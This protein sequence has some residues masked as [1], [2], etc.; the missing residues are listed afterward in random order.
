VQ[1]VFEKGLVDELVVAMQGQSGALPLLE[2]TLDQLVRRRNGYQLTFQAY[3]QI[4]G[5][6]G[7]L[8]QHAE[9]T[10]QGLPTNDHRQ[11]ARAIFL[12]LIQPGVTEQD[13]TRRRAARSEFDQD[14]PT[15]E[16]RI[17]ETLD[18]FIRA[19]LLTA[20]Q[21]DGT[22][23]VE[24]SH[25]A[26]IRE[27]KRLAEW[28]YEARSDIRLQE[29]LSEDTR[30]WEQRK[31][32]GDRLYRGTQLKEA[33]AWARR[34]RPSTSE[35]AF[36]QASAR[37]RLFWLASVVAFVLVL[38]SSM[39]ITSWSVFFQPNP[40]LVTSLQDNVVGSLRWC[41]DHA[42]SQKTTIRF[43]PGLKGVIELTEGDL[44][45]PGGKSF[46]LIGPGANQLAIS[47]GNFNAKMHIAQGA[48]LTISGLSFINSQTVIDAFLFNEGT[49]TISNSVISHNQTSA[50][51]I[52]YGG[53]IEN[54]GTLTAIDSHIVN[55]IARG[56][57]KGQGG[58]IFNEGKLTV[59]RTVFSD[60][61]AISS[62]GYGLG[63]AID[64]S[65]S[66]N[67][68]VI[69]STFSMNTATGDTS[70]YGG[71]IDSEGKLMVTDSTFLHNLVS[72]TSSDGLSDGYGGGIYNGS[73]GTVTITGSLFSQNSASAPSTAEGGGIYNAGKTTLN[74]SSLLNNTASGD[75][76]RN[77]FLKGIAGGDASGG[78]IYNGFEP[79]NLTVTNS[80]ISNNVA[81]G[82]QGGDG[83]GGGIYNDATLTVINTTFW[84]NEASYAGGGIL[85]LDNKSDSAMISFCT[86]YANTAEKGGGIWATSFLDNGDVTISS[87]IVADNSAR[88][89]P[90][91]F[92]TLISNGYNMVENFA[93][94]V[95]LNPR[96]D[97]QVTF[98]NL[99]VQPT[100]GNNGGPTQT[101]APL[102]GS[103]AIDAV[104][105]PLCSV[106]IT[107]VSGQS[108]TITTDQR[109][110]PRPDGSENTCDIGAY[111][112]SY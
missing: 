104:P 21:V 110:A 85:S 72:S 3:R 9:E 34:N 24:V 111:E 84:H 36:L 16:Q 95:G 81:D 66:G 57:S 73:T 70:G 88:R 7:A 42:S 65:S 14:E 40:T 52:A 18:R 86:L 4:G 107:T 108:M 50:G 49:L 39:G 44:L 13:S 15:Q 82:H 45:F 35:A 93:G 87:S 76:Y 46:T 32:P 8:S 75:G 69:G 19:R 71:S 41:V 63:G 38:A 31:H 99:G 33:Q 61:S 74:Q 2:F 55:N 80:T 106:I 26:L 1:L 27:W 5:I 29:S 62:S 100:L 47:G 48:T 94:S 20:N 103:P 102:P 53:G 37:R 98:A 112:S 11:M 6:T 51:A 64:S 10:Y 60:N 28:L 59:M 22:M 25:E 109:G 30:E 43:A 101:L 68:T 90:D 17:Q 79:A 54:R 92:G 78:G 77:I 97:Q 12:R 96:T 91:I 105:G 23:T 83:S 89:G 67:V 58:G 56:T